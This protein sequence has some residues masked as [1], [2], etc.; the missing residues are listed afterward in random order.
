M[1]TA[2][3]QTFPRWAATVLSLLLSWSALAADSALPL[4]PSITIG[5]P[6]SGATFKAPGPV[7]FEATAVDP[8]G[9]IRHLDFYE[10][11]KIVGTSDFLAKIGII[12][13]NPIPHRFEW[14]GVPAGTHQ[15]V[16]VGKSTAGTQVRSTAVVVDVQPPSQATQV[17]LVPAGAEWRYLYDGTTPAEAWRGTFDDS[18]WK[19]GPAQLGFG[20]SD[21]RTVIRTNTA[22]HPVTAY[23]RKTFEV[24]VGVRFANLRLDILRDDGAVVYLNGVEI[25][26]GNLPDGPILGSTLAVDQASD[27]NA[28]RTATIPATALK[29]GINVLSVEVHQASAS[30]SDLSFNLELA[31]IPAQSSDRPVVSV[32]ASRPATSEPSPLIRVAPGQFIFR[33][34]GDAVLPLTVGVK[35]GGTATPGLDYAKVP[36]VVV[37]PAGQ[38]DTTLEIVALSDNRYEGTENVVVEL[39]ASDVLALLGYTV[40]PKG[41]RAEITIADAD[42]PSPGWLLNVNFGL[43]TKKTGPAAVGLSANDFWNPWESIYTADVTVKDLKAHDGS[44]T[45]VVLRIENAGGAWNNQTGDGM[46]DSYVYPNSGGGDGVGNIIATLSNLPAGSYNLHLYGH[47]DPGGRPESDSTF[48]VLVGDMKYGPVGTRSSA[49]WKPADGWKE[50]SQ[51]VAF[52]D[53]EVGEGDSIRI[54]VEPGFDGVAKPNNP[55]QYI[56][57]L[58]GLQLHKASNLAPGTARITLDAPANG[59]TFPVGT[60]IVIEATAVDPA[61]YIAHVEFFDGNTRI[62]VS[63]IAFIRAPDPGTPIHHSFE[64]KGATAGEHKIYARVNGDGGGVITSD[65]VLVTVKGDGSPERIVVEIETADASATEPVSAAVS[66]VDSG[67]FVIRRVS[68]PVDVALNVFYQ[69]DGGAVSGVDFA[70]LPE[71]FTLGKGVSRAE[72]VIRPLA[73][74]LKEGDEKLVI[75]LT[76]PACI[77]IFPPPLSCYQ[78]GAKD[79]GIVVIHDA[80][81]TVNQAPRVALVAPKTGTGYTKGD[82]ITVIAEASDSDGSIARLDIYAGDKLLGS[83]KD[84]KLQVIWKEATTGSHKLTG[85]AV[86]NAGREATSATVTITVR[87]PL[88]LAFVQRILPPAYLPAGQIEVVLDAEPPRT[89]KAWTVEDRLPAGWTFVSATHE[90]GFDAVNNKVKFGPFT[91]VTVRK[92]TY[93]VAAAPNA[94]GPQVF[95]GSSSADGKSFPVAGGDTVQPAGETHPADAQPRD[96][97]IRADELTTYAAAWKSGATWGETKASIPLSYVTRAGQIWKT[98]ELYVFDVTKGAPPECWAPAPPKPGPT[99]ALAATL[100]AG[101]QGGERLASAS[102][103]PGRAERIRILVSPPAGTLSTA[104]EESVPEGWTV[105]GVNEGGVFDSASRRIRWGIFWGAAQVELEY[106]VTPPAGTASNVRFQGR[107]SFD[108]QDVA[109]GGTR[110]VGSIDDATALRILRSHRE[111]NGRVHFGVTAAPDQV[112]TIEASNDLRAWIELGTCVHTGGEVSMEDP[113]GA[114]TSAPRYYRLKPIGR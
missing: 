64:W 27:E 57:I 50:G 10:G 46:Y 34:S 73:D 53:L 21:E 87:D 12:P 66:A 17:V 36:E 26:R 74:A 52:R 5:A 84:A 67:V 97:A 18:K 105:S 76:P 58:N 86:D 1:N 110:W 96:L 30:S 75:R 82:P 11:E 59:S 83:T 3:F 111:S 23:F 14:N 68:G 33:R 108:G 51:Y 99:A 78:V 80:T 28:Y 109:L 25:A 22:P 19:V 24:G 37:F 9:D 92:L 60:P 79:T 43:W 8:K 13:G 32:A 104:V 56:A 44:A 103:K 4:E 112:Y 81:T 94:T 2:A 65:A 107:V 15:I 71:V 7:V 88:A 49:G 95:V 85:H 90:G 62:G 6:K 69:V 106:L 41:A 91:D 98:G 77:A 39:V 70:K 16:A 35:F 45:P 63:D 29:T 42:Q 40:E 48:S 20:D 55:N 102:L 54:T 47:A 113:A 31:G 61:G 101:P 89:T 93:R 72:I 114:T 100:G 38:I